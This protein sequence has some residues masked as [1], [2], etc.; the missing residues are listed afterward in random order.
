MRKKLFMVVLFA[1]AFFC[2]LACSA[3]TVA[4]SDNASQLVSFY[5]QTAVPL[6]T[7]PDS[8][9]VN[10][11]LPEQ[12]Y[13]KTLTQTFCRDYQFCLVDGLIYYKLMP[14]AK[15]SN[16]GL[17]ETDWQLVG[18][19]GL[20]TPKR[21]D[22]FP[23]PTEIVEISADADALLAFDSE[24]GMY[25]MFT[26]NNSPGKPFE[27]IWDFG[28]PERTHLV[29]N[30]LVKNK[31]AWAAATRR[32]DV[33]WHEDIYGNPHHYGTMGIE[34]IYFLTEDGQHIRFTD[35]GLP[36]DFS[37]SLQGPERGTFIAEN[38]SASASTMFVI[39][40][41]GTMYTRLADFDTIGCDPMFFKY[42]YEN[43]P[44][45]YDGTQYL[46]NYSPW[47][48]PSEPWL[49]QPDIPLE[50]KARI[51]RHITILQN[52]QGNAARELRV[53]GTNAQ[54]STGYYTKAIFDSSPE[55]WSFV[56]VP[57]HLDS[58]SF[59]PVT[60]DGVP[61]EVLDNLS[62][63]SQD[64]KF[65][66]SVWQKGH[67]LPEIHCS[68]SDFIMSEGA[69]T[70]H[71][72]YKDETKSIILHP[73]EMWSFMFRNDPGLDGT[74]KD[75]FITFEYPAGSLYSQYPE[76]Q[77]FLQRAFGD[78]NKV[79]FSC[80]ASVTEDIFYLAVPYENLR[81]AHY[82]LTARG[83]AGVPVVATEMPEK[84]DFVFLL[85]NPHHSEGA[86]NLPV[87]L[88]YSSP[89]VGYFSSEELQ[90]EPGTVITQENRQILDKTLAKNQQYHQMLLQE[91]DLFDKYASKARISRWGYNFV[92][93][94]T[95]VTL[96]NQI[97]FP[98]IKTATSF[99]GELLNQN[100]R[101]YRTQ[102]KSRTWVYSH[103]LE[104]L[105]IRIAAYK[106]LQ[107][108][109]EEGKPSATVPQKL[110]ANHYEYLK[111]AHLPESM[112]GSSPLSQNGASMLHLL[113][114]VPLFPGFCLVLQEAGETY[115]VL[116]ELEDSVKTIYR[117]TT[118]PSPANPLV[119]SAKFVAFSDSGLLPKELKGAE[120]WKGQLTWDGLQLSINVESGLFTRKAL[121]EG[122]LQ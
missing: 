90:L 92:D 99:G 30:Q 119:L 1:L 85:A 11:H 3:C 78:K 46:S 15:Y 34:T 114:D 75:F 94:L 81:T 80:H 12:V 9:N 42:T 121:F 103:L 39:N 86:G 26:N 97:D 71:L 72:T 45:K 89:S 43:L 107:R 120:K 66:G 27:W 17:V 5:H 112:E 116:V 109:L 52:G 51:T 55:D 48:L 49:R 73:V 62:G 23:V 44:Q 38:L 93:L 77:D 28:F 59:L 47:A 102:A 41:A 29:Q 115:Y 117:R 57:L 101:T 4:P 16:P 105:E 65:T 79:L 67:S 95:T 53:A 7:V 58:S 64:L 104:L 106:A 20:P 60:A 68:I 14:G 113:P 87:A 2:F 40:K 98:K 35:S 32:Q 22:G 122:S 76:F 50:G 88:Y 56:E 91:L 31:R 37:R 70:L 110:F 33:L 100:A 10:G 36:A 82:P 84:D 118:S 13:I 8:A 96:L 108:V 21:E 24:G 25:Q 61:Q 69:F 111:S 54:G 6:A 74:Q 83:D 19:T 63:P 18:G